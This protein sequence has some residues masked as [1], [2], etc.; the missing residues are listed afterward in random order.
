MKWL[1]WITGAV[2]FIVIKAEFGDDSIGM[3]LLLFGILLAFTLL[4]KRAAAK[5]KKI[6]RERLIKEASQIKER[7]RQESAE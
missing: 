1:W 7:A 2:L 3:Y 5:E 4:G 6:E